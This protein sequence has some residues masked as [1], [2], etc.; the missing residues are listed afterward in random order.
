MP[1]TLVW[2]RV[3]IV[4]SQYQSL[5]LLQASHVRDGMGWEH[6]LSSIASLVV[7]GEPLEVLVLNPRHPVLVLVVV[8]IF[9]PL[10]VALALLLVLREGVEG[11]LLLIFAH[12][13]PFVAGGTGGLLNLIGHCWCVGV[14]SGGLMG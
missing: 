1:V 2:S 12:G 6:T 13:V 10:C 7:V 9:H 4:E 3:S 5:T 8:A 11:L 14:G